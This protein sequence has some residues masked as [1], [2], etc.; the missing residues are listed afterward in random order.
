MFSLVQWRNLNTRFPQQLSVSCNPRV[1]FWNPCWRGNTFPWVQHA[2][3]FCRNLTSAFFYAEIFP[4]LWPVWESCSGSAFQIAFYSK[5]DANRNVGSGC[6]NIAKNNYAKSKMAKHA[7]REEKHLQT[8]SSTHSPHHNQHTPT[9][10]ANSFHHCVY[11]A[12]GNFIFCLLVGL[13]LSSSGTCWQSLNLICTRGWK[14]PVG[15]KTG[16]SEI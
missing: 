3:A 14:A 12:S 4:S 11:F 16:I 5:Q 10:T 15:G 6:Q 2:D 7:G 8:H 1:P 13:I 9:A